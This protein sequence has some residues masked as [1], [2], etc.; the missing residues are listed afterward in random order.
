MRTNRQSLNSWMVAEKDRD[1][2]FDHVE[3]LHVIPVQMKQDMPRFACS[4]TKANVPPGF[5]RTQE[6]RLTFRPSSEAR[7][8]QLGVHTRHLDCPR[9]FPLIEHPGKQPYTA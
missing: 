4:S 3:R 9:T 8:L 6:S 7:S 2:A 5:L 1:L